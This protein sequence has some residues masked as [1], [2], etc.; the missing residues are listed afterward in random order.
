M[1]RTRQYATATERQAAYRQR[2]KTTTIWVD[3][4]PFA[5]IDRAI[6]ALQD[7]TSRARN[8]GNP[9]AHAISRATPVDTLE[10]AVAWILQQIQQHQ[11][12]PD[13]QQRPDT[14][15]KGKTC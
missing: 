5:R 11:G 7:A 13:E 15:K 6:G 14:T 1:G 9:L 12:T 10:A 3:R 4:E 8:S 2:M